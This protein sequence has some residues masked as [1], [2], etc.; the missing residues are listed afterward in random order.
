MV[1]SSRG[2]GL[3]EYVQLKDANFSEYVLF[4]RRSIERGRHP[5]Y[6]REC[7][8]GC[9]KKEEAYKKDLQIR[10]FDWVQTF[11]RRMPSV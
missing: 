8:G 10:F 7:L 5:K 3:L 4:G 2:A 1:L 11:L 9:S 6:G